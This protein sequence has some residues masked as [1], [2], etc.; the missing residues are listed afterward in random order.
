[1]RRLACRIQ[2][3]NPSRGSGR[4]P[5]GS[6]GDVGARCCA[7]RSPGSPRS[8]IS[9]LSILLFVRVERLR[10]GGEIPKDVQSQKGHSSG[11]QMVLMPKRNVNNNEND[12]TKHPSSP[13]SFFLWW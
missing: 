1:M 8:F 12:T 10:P 7:L 6:W 2:L 3:G 13:C 9:P 5:Q 4:V 11:D